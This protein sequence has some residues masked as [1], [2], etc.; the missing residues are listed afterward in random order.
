MAAERNPE[1]R[2]AVNTLLRL[3]KDERVRAEYTARLIA[4][5]DRNSQLHE[6]LE[7]KAL[8]I[9]QKLKAMG[10]STEQILTATGIQLK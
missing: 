7:E 1:I 5:L 9:A 6:A 10:L 3:S 8:D 4:N 2:K